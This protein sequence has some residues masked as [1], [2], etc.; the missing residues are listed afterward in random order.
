MRRRRELGRK[1]GLRQV[2]SGVLAV[3]CLSLALPAQAALL[4]EGFFDRVPEPGQGQAAIEANYLSQDANGIV[5]ATGQVDM[6][7][8]G[9][10]A[11]ADRLIYNTHTNDVE[12]IGH[13]VIRDPDGT[14]YSTDRVEV[15][16]NFKRAILQSMVMITESGAMV[17][18]SFIDH[19]EDDVTI[20]D[21]GTYAP[22]GTCIDSKGRRI[23]WRVRTKRMVYDQD[24][25]LVDL[26]QPVLEVLGV[27]VAWLPWIRLPD[28]S[29]PRA[30]GFRLP[31]YAYSD[32]IG[33]KLAFPYFYAAGDDI[34]LTLTPVLLSRQGG[35]LS[36]TIDQRFDDWG[37]YSVTGSGLY[38]LDRGAFAGTAGDRDWRGAIQTSTKFTPTNEWTF[39]TAYTVF[40]DR[41]YLRDYLLPTRSSSVNEIYAEYLTPETYGEARVQEFVVLGDATQADQD[42]QGMALPTARVEHVY[43]LENAGQISVSGRFL[44]VRRNADST[45]NVNGVPYVQGYAENKQHGTL[46]AGWSKQWTTSAGVL[47]TPYVGLRADFAH[48]DGGGALLPGASE[49]FNATPIAALDVRY[50]FVAM[51]GGSTHIIEPIGQIVYRASDETAVGVTNDNAQSFVFDDTNLFSFNRFS[52]TDR[53][54]T[55]LRA[56]IGGHYLADFEDGSYL[57]FIAGQSFHLGGVNALGISDAAQTG[58]SSGLGNTSS[59]IVAGVQGAVNDHLSFG[60]KVQIDPT[61][62]TVVRTAVAGSAQ[63]E[64]WKLSLDYAYTLADPLLGALADQQDIG[65]SLRI[66]LHEYWYVTAAAGWDITKSELLDHSAA[67]T[68]DDGYFEASGIYSA[69]GADP[70][71]PAS[72]SYKISF[73]LKSP[74]G[75]DYGS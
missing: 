61:N 10:Y 57:D 32:K 19:D 23:G 71:N 72:Q 53:Q 66:P 44:N 13:V 28:P 3:V 69:T 73:K 9:Y 50:P 24:N 40:S 55:G 39:G 11:T 67:L 7:Y 15:T 38:Q 65:G 21:D 31:S 1:R 70:F 20:L 18:S 45:T 17:T 64:G 4:P 59:Y 36:A 41:A 27:P 29:N 25:E 48:Y 56:N 68:Y 43:D 46:E 30:K 49:L 33:L 35:L 60:A 6:V 62:V 51:D 16:G 52:G 14:E 63:Y 12:L 2:F 5:T 75:S 58:T 37:Q 26:E 8:L 42:E 74:D 34:D 22:C 47:L 54:E